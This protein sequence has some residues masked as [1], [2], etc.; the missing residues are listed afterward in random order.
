VISTKED[1]ERE[2]VYNLMSLRFPANAPEKVLKDMWSEI[3][4]GRST[5]WS[6]IGED[7][8]ECIRGE[9]NACHITDQVY[10]NCWF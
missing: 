7:R 9:Q 10:D 6:G 8:K 1:K 2:A 4:E 5:L 3:V